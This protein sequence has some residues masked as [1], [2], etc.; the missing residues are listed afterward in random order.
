MLTMI[1]C[2]LIGCVATCALLC[3][4]FCR[5]ASA[6]PSLLKLAVCSQLK[7]DSARL[8]C[9]D[10]AMQELRERKD[11]AA[12]NSEIPP[13]WRITED[14]SPIDDSP[15][16]SAVLMSGR[17]SLIIRC[18]ERKTEIVL[19]T[20]AYLGAGRDYVPVLLRVND[21]PAVNESWLPS[22]SGRGAFAPNPVATLQALPDNATLFVR[23]TDYSGSLHDAKFNVGPISEVREKVRHACKSPD[24]SPRTR[25]APTK[26]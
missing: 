5:E 18:H 12:Q 22:S 7:D 11:E 2:K 21:T 16:I 14:T 25:N 24:T 10:E 13:T 4:G 15:Q 20:D 23:L 8:K 17:A 19:A 6:Q 3:S 9:Y 26:R 1:R